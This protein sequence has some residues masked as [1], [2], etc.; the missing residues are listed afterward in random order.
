MA[1]EDRCRRRALIWIDKFL[2][3][4]APYYFCKDAP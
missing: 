3:V 1:V 4:I 2:D